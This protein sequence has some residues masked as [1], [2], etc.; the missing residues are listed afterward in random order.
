M[1]QVFDRLCVV[2]Q[3]LQDAKK[4]GP[5]SLEDL[6]PM[7]VRARVRRRQGLWACYS[8]RTVHHAHRRNAWP[9]PHPPDRRSWTAL[10]SADRRAC[11]QA[12]PSMSLRAKLCALTSWRLATVRGLEPVPAAIV[13]SFPHVYKTMMMMMMMM[14]IKNI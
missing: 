4:H 7:Q 14:M 2:S 8:G 3:Q 9:F 1:K 11:L 13:F 12:A 10:T 5:V 6:R